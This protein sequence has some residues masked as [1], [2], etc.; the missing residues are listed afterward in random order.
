MHLART[1]EE[2]QEALQRALNHLKLANKIGAKVCLLKSDTVKGY[3]QASKSLL[4]EADKLGITLMIQ[5][6]AGAFP[7]SP[8]EC[9][10]ILAVCDDPRLKAV[11]EVGQFL[12]A[13]HD[14]KKGFEVLKNHIALVHF[15]DVK[16]QEVVAWGTGDLDLNELLSQLDSI[17]YEGNFVIEMEKADDRASSLDKGIVYIKE[18]MAVAV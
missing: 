5:N 17:Q 8:S 13:G 15:K 6:H 3:Q 18:Q 11:L 9:Q 4:P 12:V 14:W 16:N 7:S 2:D 1:L 10:E